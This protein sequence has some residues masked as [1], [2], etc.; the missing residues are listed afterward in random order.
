MVLTGTIRGT[1]QTSD[2]KPVADAQVVIGDHGIVRTNNAG[3]FFMLRVPRGKHSLSVRTFAAPPVTQVVSV[4]GGDTINVAVRLR[5]KLTELETVRTVGQRLVDGPGFGALEDFYRRRQRG[6]GKF[7]D[8]AQLE[9]SVTFQQLVS[10]NMAGVRFREDMWGN[11][12]VQF[13]RCPPV[14]GRPPVVF[15]VDG[16]KTSAQEVFSWFRPNDLE[17]MEIYRGPVE[18]PIEARGD[19][20]A[21]VYFWTRR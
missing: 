20:C 10:S 7:F 5:Q 14:A 18:L 12:M 11:L 4:A 17:A 21:A 8:R 15:F 13:V 3:A 2:G 1:V 9:Q 6:F 16:M 19:A